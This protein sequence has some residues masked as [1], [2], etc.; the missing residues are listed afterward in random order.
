ME[1]WKDIEGYEGRYQVSNLG[2]VK[3]LAKTIDVGGKTK[4]FQPE[5]VLKP[6]K[7]VKGYL[8]VALYKNK[9]SKM[10]RV[11]RLVAEAFIPNPQKMPSVNHKDENK[12]NNKA[13]NL[14]WCT[15]KY[16]NLYGTRLKKVSKP[17]LQLNSNGELLKE[18]ESGKKAMREL[19]ISDASI[20]QCC[21]GIRKTAGGFKWEYKIKDKG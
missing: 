1:I 7:G 17:I 15:H 8:L 11:H 6:S 12:E 21:K 2:R 20:S 18:W 16:N 19:K 5:R 3:S 13:E 14:E 9:R 10:K 4:R